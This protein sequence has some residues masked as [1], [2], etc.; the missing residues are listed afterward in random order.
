MKSRPPRN[1]MQWLPLLSKWQHKRTQ[2]LNQ[3]PSPQPPHSGTSEDTMWWQGNG[4]NIMT[5][6]TK[7]QRGA[8]ITSSSD[9]EKAV[10]RMAL[11][12]LLP[13]HA[14]AA[15][16]EQRISTPRRFHD[17]PTVGLPPRGATLFYSPVHEL[18]KPPSSPISLKRQSTRNA[19]VAERSRKT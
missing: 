13:S 9:E 15:T 12:W 1:R 14:A 5:L 3:S 19:L 10:M 16:A 6:L 17:R 11:E 8:A 7:Q 2:L 18:V 4:G